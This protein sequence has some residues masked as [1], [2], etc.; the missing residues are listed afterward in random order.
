MA[1]RRGRGAGLKSPREPLRFH[2]F[3]AHLT[4]TQARG[5]R[6]LGGVG[7]RRAGGAW[8]VYQWRGPRPNDLLYRWRSLVPV[9][10][11]PKIMWGSARPVGNPAR[12]RP[13][14]KLALVRN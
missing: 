2:G 6:V 14:I 5:P 9:A 1:A 12:R 13:T 4:R 8:M 7:G 3:P 10:T 11:S